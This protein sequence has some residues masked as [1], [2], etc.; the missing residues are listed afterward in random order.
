MNRHITFKGLEIDGRLRDFV[1]ELKKMGFKKSSFLENLSINETCMEGEF[2]REKVVVHIKTSKESG[3][4]F[5]ITI[6]FPD[7]NENADWYTVKSLYGKYKALY[8]KKYGRPN[9]S[10]ETLNGY[11][12]DDSEL[13]SEAFE[14]GTAVYRTSYKTEFGTINLGVDADCYFYITYRDDINSN[15]NADELEKEILDEI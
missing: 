11:C 15:L 8:T 1:N 6:Y 5:E 13:V 7:L 4:V 9:H 10:K 14:K 2:T 12:R 3:V